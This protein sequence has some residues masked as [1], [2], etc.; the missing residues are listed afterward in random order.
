MDA[1]EPKLGS[2][3][4]PA[5]NEGAVIRRCLD[6]LFTGLDPDEVEVVVACNGCTDDTVAQARDAGYAIT[7]LDLPEP[8][9][10]GAIRAAERVVTALP[11]LFLD[12]DVVMSGDTV[13]RVLA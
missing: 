2:I 9:K 8:G 6:Q 12:A 7:V 4:I 11:R 1:T 5:Y 13:R 3:V 10:V